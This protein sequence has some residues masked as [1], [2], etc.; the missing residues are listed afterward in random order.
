M[1]GE[2]ARLGH[3]IGTGTSWR[4]FLRAQ[5]TGLLSA[6]LFHLDTTGL[7]R[8]YVQFVM[9]V[10]TRRVHILGVTDHPTPA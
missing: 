2:L 9:E 4:S 6:D 5:A 7:H 8:L 1:Q 10:H 3:R